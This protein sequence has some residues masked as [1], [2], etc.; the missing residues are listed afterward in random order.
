MCFE[1]VQKQVN[2]QA[3]LI[4]KFWK[5]KQFVNRGNFELWPRVQSLGAKIAKNLSLVEGY[6]LFCP[7]W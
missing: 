3:H 6:H 2:L 5:E 1:H 4:V 7:F